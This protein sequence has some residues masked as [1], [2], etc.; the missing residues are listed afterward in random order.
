MLAETLQEL[1]SEPVPGLPPFHSGLVGYLGYDVVRRLEKLPD[2]V[3][4]DLHLPELTM[5]LAS[6]LAVFDHH[7]GELWLIAN[8]INF[9]GTDEGV[10]RA[11]FNAVA[12][13][14]AMA[15]QLRQPRVSLACQEG[16]PTTRS[17]QGSGPPRSTWRWS[18]PRRRRSGRV[19][20]SRS[21][22]RSASTSAPTPTRSRC[23]ALCGSRTPALPLPVEDAGLRHH[24]L[25]P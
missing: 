9:D 2:G 13:V 18:R 24:R 17:S 5:M 10:E 4:D 25:Q 21:W 22:S 7:R 23:T 16:E 11:Y 20:P 19:R 1:A 6:E 3:E 14:E 8:A 12:A 15:Q